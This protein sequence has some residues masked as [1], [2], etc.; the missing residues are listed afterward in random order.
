MNVLDIFLSVVFPL[1]CTACGASDTPLC[2]KCLTKVPGAP[3]TNNPLITA[4]YT[5]KHTIIKKALWSLKYRNNIA[6]AE[7]FGN[8]LYEY[9]LE[10][11]YEFSVFSSASRDDK[12]IIVPIPLYKR[13]MRLRGF[14]QSEKI[15]A[16]LNRV[17]KNK[18]FVYE[19]NIL[20][21]IKETTPQTSIK[22][23]LERSRNIRGCFAVQ[24]PEKIKNKVVIVIDDITTT[25][26][27]LNEAIKILENDGAAKVVGI[28][29]AH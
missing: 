10:H 16:A 3:D 1:R 13:R 25:G 27:T 4:L 18:S 23:K 28:A 24:N 12:P 8:A 22:N 29:I 19:N 7:V 26:A 2:G 15:V 6:L 20:S 17:D 5:Y 11:V 14:N 9:L 21:K